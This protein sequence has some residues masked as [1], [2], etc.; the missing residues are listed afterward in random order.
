MGGSSRRD[1]VLFFAGF[2]AFPLCWM[3]WH[4]VKDPMSIAIA[5]GLAPQVSWRLRDRDPRRDGAVLQPARGLPVNSLPGKTGPGLPDAF[6]ALLSSAPYGPL[7]ENAD[8]DYG[9]R[10]AVERLEQ[11]MRL[12]SSNDGYMYENP[13]PLSSIGFMPFRPI[14]LP[15]ASELDI[16]I[17]CIR[18]L[19]FLESWKAFVQPY[20][21]IIIQVPNHRGLRGTAPLT[22][23]AK[24]R[25]AI[26][27]NS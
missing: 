16:V 22:I 20:H 4:A 8:T 2:A 13:L 12:K 21:V 26:P 23:P 17:P 18:D 15:P 5:T 27:V 1:I 7:D 6:R 24:R 9:S 3:F 25:T 19:T 14:D 11:E 10:T